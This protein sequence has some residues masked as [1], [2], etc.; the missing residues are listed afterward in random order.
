MSKIIENTVEVNTYP[1]FISS[2]PCGIDKFEGKS[3]ERL[4]RAIVSHI[5][6]TD[7]VKNRYQVPRIIGLEGTWGA[8]K[9]N[10]IKQVKKELK[11][12]YYVFEYDAWGHQE[13]LQRRSF[14]ETLTAE[15]IKAEL[16]NGDTEVTIGGKKKV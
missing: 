15:L 2:K 11:S 13:D 12:E 3:Q 7:S 5:R 1:H 6:K 9:S 4:T 8:G 16:F 10:V 14:L